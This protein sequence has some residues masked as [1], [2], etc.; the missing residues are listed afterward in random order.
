MAYVTEKYIFKKKNK[1]TLF[2]KSHLDIM[3][4]VLDPSGPLKM[5]WCLIYMCTFCSRDDERPKNS[6]LLL[7]LSFWSSIHYFLT[8]LNCNQWSELFTCVQENKWNLIWTCICRWIYLKCALK[9]EMFQPPFVLIRIVVLKK[10]CCVKLWKWT[11]E[12]RVAYLEVDNRELHSLFEIF[13]VFFCK[14]K[15]NL[16]LPIYWSFK[17]IFIFFS[18]EKQ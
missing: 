12:N 7:A 5:T 8:F 16:L 1:F 17:H 10:I 15:K 18:L 6:P 14:R 2:S 11:T 9:P 13:Q 3:V 4:R